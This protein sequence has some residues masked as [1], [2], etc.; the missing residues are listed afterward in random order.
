MARPLLASSLIVAVYLLFTPFTTPTVTSATGRHQTGQ[1]PGVILLNIPGIVE[2]AIGIRPDNY[3]LALGSSIND[4]DIR[5]D[6]RLFVL[7]ADGNVGVGTP[8]PREKL[9]VAGN[10]KVGDVVIRSGVGPPEGVVAGGVGDL[11]LRVDGGE[12]STL[13]VKESGGNSRQGWRAR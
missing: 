13:Y 10:V 12:G 8:E 9:E 2:Y 6:D 7:S 4:G 1:P 11:Y 3:H 5:N